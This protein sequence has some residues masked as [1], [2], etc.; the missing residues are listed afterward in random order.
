VEGAAPCW[1]VGFSIRIGWEQVMHPQ[2]QFLNGEGFRQV[3][4]RP[5]RKARHAVVVGAF[6]RE[7]NDPQAL[8]RE[9]LAEAPGQCQPV[10]AR[11]HDVAE[12]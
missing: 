6:S 7:Q 1:I 8:G 10:E 11:H 3:V 4:I 2:E 5:G 12:Q 9:V